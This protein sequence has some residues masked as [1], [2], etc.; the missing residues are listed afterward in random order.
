MKK[1][2]FILIS[3]SESNVVME[4]DSWHGVKI[5]KVDE[6]CVTLDD[7]GNVKCVSVG[8]S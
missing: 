7:G 8:E 2:Q 4:G 6:N 5:L 3:G 1:N